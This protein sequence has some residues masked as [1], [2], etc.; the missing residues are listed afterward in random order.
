MYIQ[1]MLLYSA[2]LN[3]Y[4]VPCLTLGTSAGSEAGQSFVSEAST[5]KLQVL[6]K[7]TAAYRLDL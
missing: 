7:S 1:V 5:F 6:F 4:C 2:L 3:V